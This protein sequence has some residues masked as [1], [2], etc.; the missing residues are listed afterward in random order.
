MGPTIKRPERDSPE[1][2]R[3]TLLEVLKP[4]NVTVTHDLWL[5][6]DTDTLTQEHNTLL[7]SCHE[8][9][10]RRNMTCNV[11]QHTIRMNY[12]EALSSYR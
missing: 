10:Q 12:N 3:L 6:T 4:E 11:S 8:K 5:R 9:I 2:R 7:Y 1:R